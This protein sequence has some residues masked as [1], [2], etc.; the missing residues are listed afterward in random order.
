MFGF[1]NTITPQSI[2]INPSWLLLGLISFVLASD[3]PP[4]TLPK[5]FLEQLPLLEGFDDQEFEQFII[6]VQQKI[7]PKEAINS[8]VQESISTHE[9]QEIILIEGAISNE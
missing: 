3:A 7:V 1:L 8:V 4:A 9:N 2:R 6:F 5:G